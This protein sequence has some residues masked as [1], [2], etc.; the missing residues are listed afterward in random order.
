MRGQLISS[1]IHFVP[2][3]SISLLFVAFLLAAC[4]S[5]EFQD[6]QDFVK[7]SGADLRGQ[8]EPAP[9]IKP[10]EPFPYDN[11]SGL[12][13]PFKIRKQEAKNT[14]GAG[15][16]NQPDFSRPKQELEDFPL[17]SMKMVGYLRKG[18]AGNAIIRSSEGKL[19]RVKVG[20]YVGMNFGQIISITETEIKIKEMV[21]DGAGDWL[22]RESSLQL[23][24]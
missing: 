11:S 10:Y 3:K 9:E 12:P 19:H 1:G 6:L 23:V 14:G 2:A 17:E 18:N 16:L 7:N 22:E 15:G 24:E 8:V 13:D 21:Q 20:N 4:G 5:E